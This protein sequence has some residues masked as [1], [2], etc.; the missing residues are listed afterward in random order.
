[1]KISHTKLRKI[2]EELPDSATEKEARYLHPCNSNSKVQFHG[3]EGQ[4]ERW[5]KQVKVLF[6]FPIFKISITLPRT[7]SKDRLTHF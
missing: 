4:I 6:Q 7:I 3:R 2:S 5:E 1:M